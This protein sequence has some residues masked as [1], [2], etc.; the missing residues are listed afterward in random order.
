[1]LRGFEARIFDAVCDMATPEQWA[2]W[3]RIPLCIAAN[4]KDAEL[5]TKLEAVGVKG[6]SLHL[7]AEHG[8]L[9]VVHAL[10]AAAADPS[11]LVDMRDAEGR[12]ALHVAANEGHRSIVE[13][14]LQNGADNST[15]TKFEEYSPLHLAAKNGHLDVVDVLLS[16]AVPGIV[17]LVNVRGADGY[18]PLHLAARGGHEKIAKKLLLKGAYKDALSPSKKLAPLHLAVGKGDLPMVDVLLAAGADV[19]LVGEESGEHWTPILIAS[20]KGHK[21][22]VQALLLNGADKNKPTHWCRTAPLHQAAKN[23]HLPVV[24]LLLAEDADVNVFDSGRLW[25]PLHFA[26]LEGHEHIV[27]RLL[28]YG[29]NKNAEP[30]TTSPL[31]LAARNGHLRAVEIL[32]GAGA[33]ANL[34]DDTEMEEGWTPLH[35]AAS[36]GHK[37]VVQALVDGG[38][39]MNAV[40]ITT[41]LAPLHLAIECE[42][43][44][45]VQTLLAAGANIN[46]LMGLTNDPVLTFVAAGGEAEM[47]RVL[48]RYGADV[49]VRGDDDSTALHMAALRANVGAMNVLLEAGAN[50]EAEAYGGTVLHYAVGPNC[51]GTMLVLLRAGANVHSKEPCTRETPLHKVCRYV[52]EGAADAVDLLLRWGANETAIGDEGH[53]AAELVGVDNIYNEVRGDKESEAGIERLRALLANAPADRAWRRGRGFLIMCRAFPD[54]LRPLHI[55]AGNNITT[56]TATTE[57]GAARTIASKRMGKNAANLQRSAAGRSCSDEARSCLDEQDNYCA[58]E[59]TTCLS[60]QTLHEQSRTVDDEIAAGDELMTSLVERVVKLEEGVFRSIITYL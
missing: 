46:L 33:D 25:T 30:E 16:A 17:S 20:N 55:T 48:L 6:S 35:D 23:G 60:A 28:L 22:I 44:P 10:F 56:S 53:T 31:H 7:A 3:M 12:T 18:T 26:A 36:A 32:L 4:L 5:V 49:N 34:V 14:L 59:G 45:V 58:R 50:L 38:A 40:T 2:Q 54:R 8:N 27:Q 9:P 42:Y 47:L 39:D 19:N 15:R 24:K 21:T 11:D 51:C 41:R 1:M 37:A 29:A 13:S 43:L 52:L 57:N